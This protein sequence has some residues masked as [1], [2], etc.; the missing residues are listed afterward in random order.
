MEDPTTALDRT[1]DPVAESKDYQDLMVGLVGDRDPAEIQART[2][3]EVEAVLADA[4]PH[5]TTRPA[6]DEWS[7]LEV[8]GHMVDAEIVSA[9]RYRWTIAHDE[10]P[11]A[12][13]DQD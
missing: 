2:A 9:G 7:V 8:F 12:S 3:A 11:M 5:L 1:V 13:Y 6:P 4:G 10:P